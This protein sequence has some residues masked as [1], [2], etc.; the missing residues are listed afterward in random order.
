VKNL[1][2][3]PEVALALVKDKHDSVIFDAIQAISR[4]AY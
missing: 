1:I 2:K 3:I 4:E